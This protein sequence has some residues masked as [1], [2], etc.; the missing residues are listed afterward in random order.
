MP[1]MTI[2]KLHIWIVLIAVFICLTSSG[3]A[4]AQS[5]DEYNSKGEAKGSKGD[6]KGALQ[7]YSKAIELDP[8]F[9]KAYGNRAYVRN[10]LGDYKGVVEDYD[11][12]IELIQL[13][14]ARI[15]ERRLPRASSATMRGR[16][17]I[18][19]FI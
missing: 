4:I 14:T 1:V 16:S 9:V 13:N 6:W 11:K 12:V 17:G 19:A 7:D 10:I 2:F 18:L 15:T 3:A 5:A 8:D